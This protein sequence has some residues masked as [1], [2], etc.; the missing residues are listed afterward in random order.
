[1]L[2]VLHV[3]QPTTGGVARVVTGLARAQIAAG[4]AVTVACPP[5]AFAELA[6]AGGARWSRWDCT[7]QPGPSVVSELRALRRI[8]SATRP[9]VVHLH[10]SKAGLIGRLGLRG[11]VPT[12]FQ[13]H[14]WSFAATG[15]VMGVAAVFWERHATRWTDLLLYCSRLEQATGQQRGITGPGRVVLNGVD[16]TTYPRPAPG[17]Q[18]AARAALG[19]AGPGPFAAVVARGCHQ[20]GQDI[21]IRSWQRVRQVFPDAVLF[22]AGA[23]VDV[24]AEHS[25]GVVA[26]GPRDDVRQVYLASD[27]VLVPSRWEGMSLALLEGMACARST[28]A[29]DVA[30]NREALLHGDLPGAGAIVAPEDADALAD[31]V[32][33]RFARPEVLAAEGEAARLR[34]MH[35]FS[36]QETT[37]CVEDAYR[38]V[39]RGARRHGSGHMSDAAQHGQ[40]GGKHT[41]ER[42]D[43]SAAA[44]TTDSRPHGDLLMRF[45]RAPASAKSDRD[46]TVLRDDH[47]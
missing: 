17:E 47:G 35:R 25:C 14:A 26:L 37:R 44:I 43:V 34:V 12:L 8:V 18:A 24:P 42:R 23:G 10:S 4:H 31:A 19:L 1:M 21:A 5:G 30:G 28:V 27:L 20:K 2:S 9:E 33:T 40:S 15:S 6:A 39:L 32:I 3:T 45:G 29:T 38:V 46:G 22:L 41:H 36:E 13:P 16:L 11:R 7:R